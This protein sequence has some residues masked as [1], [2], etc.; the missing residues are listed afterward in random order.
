MHHEEGVGGGLAGLGGADDA[1]HAGEDFAGVRAVLFEEMAGYATAG[2]GVDDVNF[3]ADEAAGGDGCL[4]HGGVGEFLHVGELALAVGQVLHDGADA[5]IRHFDPNRL[6][7]FH[8]NAIDDLLDH[9]G[10]GDDELV[11][12]AAHGLDENGDLHGTTGLDVENT[13]AISVL[14]VDGD[15]GLQL[16]HEALANLAGGD[17]LAFLTDERAVVDGELHLQR[18]R[19]DL[20]EG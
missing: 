16:A 9:G 13:G 6:I 11:A 14:D 19:V 8:A 5:L 12:L 1:G 3:E 17:E 20:G 2:G 15:V 7:G 4:D 10:A 18:G